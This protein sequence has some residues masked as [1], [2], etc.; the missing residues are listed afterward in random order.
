MLFIIFDEVSMFIFVSGVVVVFILV[1]SVTVVDDEALS[2][3]AVISVPRAIIAN[4]FFIV[5]SLKFFLIGRKIKETPLN[6]RRFLYFLRKNMRIGT[7]VNL[8]CSRNWFSR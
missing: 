7:P 5:L 1:E 3:Q 2:L 8:K 6:Y 4:N